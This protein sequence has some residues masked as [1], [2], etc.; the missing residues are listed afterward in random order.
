MVLIFSSLLVFFLTPVCSSIFLMCNDYFL[1]SSCFL[2]SNNLLSLLLF[3][4]DFIAFYFFCSL[5]RLRFVPLL[6]VLIPSFFFCSSNT[7]TLFF[8]L[9]SSF[10][11][12]S[13][14]SYSPFSLPYHLC[15]PLSPICFPTLFY[16]LYSYYPVLFPFLRYFFLLFPCFLLFRSPVHCFPTLRSPIPCSCGLILPCI[17]IRGGGTLPPLLLSPLYTSSLLPCLA[18]PLLLIL[19]LSSR[20]L[21]YLLPHP[22]VG[23]IL[24]H[25]TR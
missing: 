14:F 1:P 6:H 7:V 22:L 2:I 19:H 13:T 24:F 20:P 21:G 25:H 11:R 17:N 16:H 15:S 18:S 10:L 23:L 3:Y 4:H 9:F 12:F 8:P 5:V